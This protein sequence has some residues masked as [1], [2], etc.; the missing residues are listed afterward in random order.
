[1]TETDR[2]VIPHQA[3]VPPL[4]RW[5]RPRSATSLICLLALVRHKA[6]PSPSSPPETAMSSAMS[7]AAATSR[8][9][10]ESGTRRCGGDALGDRVRHQRLSQRGAY[11][12]SGAFAAV[13]R[14]RSDPVCPSLR[15]RCWLLYARLQ[16]VL[17]PVVSL[18]RT[19]R[20]AELP[21]RPYLPF[22]G[23]GVEGAAHRSLS[24]G[25]RSSARQHG[26]TEQG[27]GAEHMVL[28]VD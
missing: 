1:M 8:L 3:P 24:F 6:A 7:A 27:T 21:A 23:A 15:L 26:E 19:R 16:A 12:P 22:D 4:C 2:L 11:R 5:S 25:F 14:R 20:R 17:L 9:I 10:P 28:S 18:R 13:R